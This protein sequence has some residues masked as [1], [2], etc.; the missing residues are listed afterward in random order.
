[1][2]KLL[3]FSFLFI[4]LSG[5][6]DKDDKE[7]VPLIKPIIGKWL[8]AETEVTVNGTKVWQPASASQSVYVI[9]R[10]D[11]VVLN[12]D[13]KANCCG[14]KELKVNGSIF[15]IKPETEVAFYINCELVNCYACPVLDIEY[16]GNE[17]IINTCFGTRIKYFRV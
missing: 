4:L 12:G 11:G 9:F 16:A 10:S 5:C 3:Y 2:K 1:M 8:V 6:K 14:T 7:P 17:M 15:E 13:G